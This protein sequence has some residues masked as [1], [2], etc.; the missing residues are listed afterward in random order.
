V[1]VGRSANGQIGHTTWH[2]TLAALLPPI[3]LGRPDDPS[4]DR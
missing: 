3:G 1:L 2:T 4:T